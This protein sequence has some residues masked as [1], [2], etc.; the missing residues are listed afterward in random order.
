MESLPELDQ[1]AQAGEFVTEPVEGKPVI[2]DYRVFINGF[3]KS[4]THLAEQMIK[5]IA[6][7]MRAPKP[8]A[9]SFAGNSWT[10]TWIEDHKLFRQLG[11]LNDGAYAKGHLGHTYCIEMFLW[12]CGATVLFI[13]RDPRD[14]AVSQVHH[15]L[16]KGQHPEREP[17]W[18]AFGPDRDF[19]AV[20]SMIIAGHQG[21]VRNNAT[22]EPNYY[23]GTIARWRHY[24]PW[25]VVPWVMNLRFEDM[26][27]QRENVAE[28]IVKTCVGR[29]ALHRGY[30]ASIPSEQ[31]DKSVERMVKATYETNKSPTFRKGTDGQWREWFDDDIKALWKAHDPP[32]PLPEN[33]VEVARRYNQHD[34]LAQADEPKSWLV[35]LGYE[36]SEDW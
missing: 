21:E 16:Y 20:L 6:P 18:A 4:G 28:S 8:W 2:V 30:V 15:T 36:Q 35:R 1:R 26:I 14:V 33:V 17:F 19:K 27:H 24:A 7:P 10:E 9:G 13:Y 25:L 23:S 12:G 22:M 3:P 34:I 31:L 32:R 5:T 11:W 29:A